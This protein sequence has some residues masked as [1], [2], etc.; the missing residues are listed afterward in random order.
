MQ[1]LLRKARQI[2]QLR[3]AF[4]WNWLSF[5]VVYWLKQK[6]GVFERQLPAAEWDHLPLSAFLKQP[7]LAG[8]EEYLARRRSEAPQFFFSPQDRAVFAPLLAAWDT[9]ENNP[10]TAADQIAQGI[11]RYFEH[12]VVTS[13]CPP[14]WHANPIT[15]ER[16]PENVH[17]SRIGDFGHGDIKFI[18]EPSRFASAFTL[19][20]AYWRTGDERYPELFWL[21]FEDWRA[22]NA[23]QQGVNWKCGQ[24]TSLR[25]MAWC[26]A[27][28]AFLDSPA[29]TPDRVVKLAEAI[30]VSG[31]RVAANLDYAL[32]QCNNH[33]ISEGMGLWTIGALFPEFREA[34]KWR[35]MGRKVLEDEGAK[36]I[37]DD[38][39]FSQNSVNYHRLMLHDYLWSLRLGDVLHQPFSAGLKKRV[40][41]AGQWLFQIEDEISGGAPCHGN[42]DGALVL[43]LNNCPYLDFRPTTQAINYLSTGEGCHE[44]GPWEEDLLWLF[45]P[46]ALQ[47]PRTALERSNLEAEDGG[48]FTLR[49]ATGFAFVRCGNFRHRPA[50]AD[51]LHCD[52]WWRGQNIALDAGTYSY[53]APEPWNN[54]LAR[55]EFHNTVTVDAL[56]QM[57]PSGKFLWLPWLHGT[58]EKPRTSENGFLNYWQGSHDG[59]ERLPNQAQHRRGVLRLGDETWLILD[60]LTSTAPHHYRVHW[61]LP[62]VPCEGEI[63]EP[64]QLETPAGTYKFTA[65]SPQGGTHSLVRADENGPR[66]WKSAHYGDHEPALSL[67]LEVEATNARF[68]TL[69][70][71]PSVSIVAQGDELTITAA[72]WRASVR[73]SAR[74][75]GQLVASVHLA[76]ALVDKLE[77]A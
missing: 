57:E 14:D 16:V 63:G 31:R 65:L 13:T 52:I 69:F 5:R 70:G 73:L 55:T 45:G 47:T 49:A 22:H 1:K 21:L 25:V 46:E 64:L 34:E 39:S 2:N 6:T 12:R 42:N 10:Q 11:W 68:F 71:P 3:Q 23:P 29:T 76:G 18:W 56:D 17:W 30:A 15:G 43:P 19:A 33:G 41:R 67:A 66:G 37:Y 4:G 72:D 20:R 53:N 60:A 7:A 74:L 51:T 59:Y 24:E 26:F 32:S 8:P 28:Y 54:S 50:H 44:A 9:P 38:G 35:L 40:Q 75:S 27:L 61:L 77:E 36:L 48:Y 62:D 58:V